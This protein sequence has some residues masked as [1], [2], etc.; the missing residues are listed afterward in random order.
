MYIV[1][2]G[3]LYVALMMAITEPSLTAAVLTFL[4]YG[5]LPLAL[6]LWVVGT[7][8]RRRARSMPHTEPVLDKVV[9]QHD[10]A[11]PDADQ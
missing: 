5:L 1:A 9:A 10:R 11:D 8:A 6:L 7:P 3:W 4:F 2:I